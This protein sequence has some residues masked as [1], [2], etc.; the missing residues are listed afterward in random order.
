MKKLVFILAT[1]FVFHSL[2]MNEKI[3]S[4]EKVKLKDVKKLCNSGLYDEGIALAM[5]FISKESDNFEV[6]YLLGNTY[7]NRASEIVVQQNKN[8]QLQKTENWTDKDYLN[9]I[10]LWEKII[11]YQDSAVYFYKKSSALINDMFLT[12][13]IAICNSGFGDCYQEFFENQTISSAR[14]YIN[15]YIS[16]TQDA[17]TS[18]NSVYQNVL[19]KFEIYKQE[20]FKKYFG[21]YYFPEGENGE[22]VEV[23]PEGDGIK[24]KVIYYDYSIQADDPSASIY[25]DGPEINLI[26]FDPSSGTGELSGISQQD[27]QIYKSKFLFVKNE[28]GC[29]D[30]K[31]SV[32]FI[33]N[34]FGSSTGFLVFCNE[35]IKKIREEEV[36]NGIYNTRY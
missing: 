26:N 33:G 2:I 18:N 23:L 27:N 8:V 19:N 6:H 12:K 4:Q 22:I 9:N 29:I 20:K 17:L 5:K 14:N 21:K 28:Y 1:V 24:F 25:S 30:L 31:L 32:P 34:S 7:A 16:N 35:K 13:N 15:V 11:N 10:S 3:F 36:L